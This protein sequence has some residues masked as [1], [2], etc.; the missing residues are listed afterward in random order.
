MTKPAC[1]RVTPSGE[2]VAVANRGGWMGNRGRLHEGRGTRHIVRNHQTKAWITC[3]LEFR[4][5]RVQ[6]W[7]PNHYTP[8]FFFDEALAFAAGHRPCAECRRRDYNAYRDA[9]SQSHYGATTYAR[10][11]DSQLH[12]ERTGT[13]KQ[14]WRE[15]PDGV[16]VDTDDGPA[17]IVGD[18]LAVFDEKTYAYGRRLPRPAAGSATVLTPPSTIEVLRA[19]YPV[20]ID[21][22]A[23]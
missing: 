12:R 20:Q 10:D 5:R 3:V 15:L 22:S 19:G 21:V 23:R 17:A 7:A 4:G 13:S 18:H 2:I 16:F 1:N 9:W 11:I 6:Q 14:P 8:L